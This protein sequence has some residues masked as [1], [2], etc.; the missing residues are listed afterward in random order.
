MGVRLSQVVQIEPKPEF[1][2]TETTRPDDEAEGRRGGA[3]TPTSVRRRAD[4]R[5][6][7]EMRRRLLP[8][9]LSAAVAVLATTHIPTAAAELTL[10]VYNKTDSTCAG[11]ATS[12]MQVHL[13]E[14]LNFPEETQSLLIKGY[15]TLRGF[16]G[17]GCCR[18]KHMFTQTPPWPLSRST[19][20]IA[21]L[22][23][24]VPQEALHA[25]RV[26][27]GRCKNVVLRRQCV[28]QVHGRAMLRA[29]LR[30][31]HHRTPRVRLAHPAVTRQLRVRRPR[32]L[33]RV[34]Q[35]FPAKH[36]R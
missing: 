30:H 35:R 36:A 2:S 21:H 24:S 7:T 33:H 9:A 32:L 26:G 8:V 17:A 31:T 34:G 22:G 14:C 27:C 28:H 13:G 6:A 29:R 11:S 16:F 19:S 5:G 15:T 4:T 20:F 3:R 12:S 18:S 25:R 1:R 23:C 10:N